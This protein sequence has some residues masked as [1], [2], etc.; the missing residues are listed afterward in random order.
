LTG[1][2][3]HSRRCDCGEQLETA[4]KM[5]VENQQGI[6]IYLRQEGRGIGL[7]KKIQA[8]TLQDQQGLDTVDANVKLG[9][10]PDLREYSVAAQ[11][12]KDLEVNSIQLITN[13][14]QKMTEIQDAG[15]MITGRIPLIVPPTSYNQFYLQTK[16]AKLGHWL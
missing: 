7:I 14:P 12:I 3:F 13:N 6:V 16:K 2:V 1:D 9:L 4:I 10:P 5:I 11:I 15:V 8:Y